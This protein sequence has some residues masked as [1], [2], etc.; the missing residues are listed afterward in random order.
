MNSNR[1]FC[2]CEYI[3]SN[4]SLRPGSSKF[5]S[6][7]QGDVQLSKKPCNFYRYFHVPYRASCHVIGKKCRKCN[8]TDYLVSFCRAYVDL[9]VNGKWVTILINLGAIVNMLLRSKVPCH[10]ALKSLVI[11]RHIKG[12]NSNL[13]PCGLSNCDERVRLRTTGIPYYGYGPANFD[14]K[15]VDLH[16]PS[17]LLRNVMESFNRDF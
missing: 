1:A 5:L 2:M 16:T 10:Q 11:S 17:F 7:P 9:I 14:L 15:L 12:T 4:A 13:L 8:A 6:R 3:G